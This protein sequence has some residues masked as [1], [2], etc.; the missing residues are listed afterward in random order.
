MS[1]VEPQWSVVPIA[2]EE[3]PQPACIDTSFSE[4]AA[5]LGRGERAVVRLVRAAFLI[6]LHAKGERLKPRHRSLR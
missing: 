3:E 6:D 4:L 1:D 2:E 5:R